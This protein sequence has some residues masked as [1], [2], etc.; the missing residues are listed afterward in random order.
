MPLCRYMPLFEDVSGGYQVDGSPSELVQ[1]VSLV[2]SH[3]EEVAGRLHQTG[4][5]PAGHREAEQWR[6]LPWDFD[7]PLGVSR[8]L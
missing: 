5:G 8:C 1:G 6:R 4:A 2:S 7:M 3:G